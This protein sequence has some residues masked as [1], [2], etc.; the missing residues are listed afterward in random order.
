MSESE[1]LH[2]DTAVLRSA[3]RTSSRDFPN[4]DTTRVQLG[5]LPSTSSTRPGRKLEGRAG[6]VKNHQ[7]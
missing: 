6:E 4:L 2:A 5:G 3:R 7:V 1:A